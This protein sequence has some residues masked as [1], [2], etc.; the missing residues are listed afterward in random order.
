MNSL[1]YAVLKLLGKFKSKIKGTQS[2]T[3]FQSHFQFWPHTAV[4]LGFIQLHTDRSLSIHSDN[5]EF[6]SE[7]A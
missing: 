2:H 7:E 3:I 5:P 6:L 1:M 4:T